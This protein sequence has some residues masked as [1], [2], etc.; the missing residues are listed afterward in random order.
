MQ[1][2]VETDK[3]IEAGVDVV[4]LDSFTSDGVKVAS[5]TW[6]CELCSKTVGIDKSAIV[7][8]KYAT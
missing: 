3:T 8:M 2:D 5:R 6:R 4:M 7:G 1:G